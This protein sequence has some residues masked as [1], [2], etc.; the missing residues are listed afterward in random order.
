M[1]KTIVILIGLAVLS[2]DTIAE[3]ARGTVF[4]DSNENGLLD[5]GERGLSN[6]RVSNGAE[7]V[8]SG[9]D[10]RYEIEIDDE[11][12]LFITKPA[13]YATP[14]NRHMLPQ[15]YYIHQPKGSPPG[16]RYQGISPTGPLPR[17]NKFPAFTE[18]GG[19]AIRGFTF[20]DTQ[21]QT[22]RELDYIRDDIIPELVGHPLCLA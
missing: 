21:P 19:K 2:L 5:P 8:L 22:N 18:A 20:A 13:N 6:V 9:A 1:I 3:V 4:I 11:A 15:F 17:G 16:L 12:I 7:I 14:V 10:G